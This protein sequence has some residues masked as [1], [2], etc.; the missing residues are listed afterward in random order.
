MQGF[1]ILDKVKSGDF[2]TIP[3]EEKEDVLMVE[4]IVSKA[5]GI[6]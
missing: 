4:I 5:F 2:S 6:Y 1:S 3:G